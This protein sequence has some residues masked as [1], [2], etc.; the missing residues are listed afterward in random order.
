MPQAALYAGLVSLPLTVGLNLFMIPRW[1]IQGAAIASDI[2][3]AVNAAVI[4][5]LFVRV[6][7]LPLPQIL[8]F[9]GS[10]FRESRDELKSK[11]I[12]R[13]RKKGKK[14]GDDL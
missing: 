11:V 8:L 13:L 2:A 3:Y 6:S 4:L 9:N 10:D 14:R 5:V 1:G 12:D 7:K